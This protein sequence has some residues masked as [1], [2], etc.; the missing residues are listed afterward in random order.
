MF[1]S[2]DDVMQEDSTVTNA[3]MRKREP[4]EVRARLIEC[5]SI[6][7]A[8]QGLDNLRLD[9]IANSA[10]VTKGGLLHHFPS[11]K[12]LINAV[13]EDLL[14]SF[15]KDIR[16]EI[17]DTEID[18]Y[19]VF[20]RAYVRVIMKGSVPDVS[21]SGL[22]LSVMTNNDLKLMWEGW[23][24]ARLKEYQATDADEILEIVR[25]AADGIW[26]A[27]ISNTGPKGSRRKAIKDRLL[28]MTIKS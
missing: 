10:G 27:D 20:T 17:S 5:A 8:T 3:H 28:G 14:E 18:D 2:K 24:K 6:V 1:N 16:K 7:A 13:F 25:C 9:A 21:W 4:E 11:K 22:S 23:Y 26:L 15:T 12:E 19:G